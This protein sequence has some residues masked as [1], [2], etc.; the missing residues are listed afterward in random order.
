MIL[1]SFCTLKYST[2]TRFERFL[3]GSHHGCGPYY[4][5]KFTILVLFQPK[6][7]HDSYKGGQRLGCTPLFQNSAFRKPKSQFNLFSYFFPLSSLFG[8]PCTCLTKCVLACPVSASSCS[9]PLL[10]KFLYPNIE[11]CK[12]ISSIE[13]G[14]YH[15]NIVENSI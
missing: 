5:S 3:S 13:F 9:L 2:R 12:C 15:Q 7:S 1:T 11:C 10:S 14:Q 4:R 6:F 8:A